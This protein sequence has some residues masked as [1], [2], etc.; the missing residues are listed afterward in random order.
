LWR[1]SRLAL[2]GALA[3]TFYPL[4]K[5]FSL[6]QIQTWLNGIIAMA[7]LAW[8]AGRRGV[9]GALVGLLLLVKPHYGLILLWGAADRAWRFVAAGAL[10]A[11]AGLAAAVLV[12]GFA[13]HID[14]MS[15]LSFLSRHG[16]TYY[17]NQSVN[18]LLNRLAGIG[19]AA[20]YTNLEFPAGVFPPY[21]VW[22]HGATVATSLCLLAVGLLGRTGREHTDPRAFATMVLCV[23]MAS[24]I[25]WEHHY[26][27]VFALF[28]ILFSGSLRGRVSL[29]L[30]LPAY[31]LVSTPV[32]MAN[33]LANSA[34]N[35]F[36]S[37][38]FAGALLLLFVTIRAAPIGQ[39]ANDDS[40]SSPER[41]P[42]EVARPAPSPTSGWTHVAQADVSA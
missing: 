21:N 39:P 32:M 5:A 36:Q 33:A 9:S 26:G 18:G 31:V 12:F 37:T 40:A 22:I 16:E 14:Y 29:H 42:D 3:L 11:G 15:I 19:D 27:A 24:P 1:L 25:A 8:A 6:G 30:L 20:R 4:V 7:L 13:T 38:L 35:V 41:Y 17:P 23:T 28:A 34:A 2:V 10:V